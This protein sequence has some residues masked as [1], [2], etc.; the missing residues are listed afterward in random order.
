M[1]NLNNG[2]QVEQR[3]RQLQGIGP[4]TI[5][6]TSLTEITKEIRQGHS[7][8][9]ICLQ[10]NKEYSFNVEPA[11]MQKLLEEYAE[12]FQE[13]KRLPPTREIDHH[14]TL[15]EGAEPIN[16]RPYRYAYF[17][18]AEIENKY[19]RC[20][21]LGLFGQAPVLFLHRYYLLKK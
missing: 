1:E 16:V 21:I 11:N 12:L 2:F 17:Q 15:K 14:I 10:I 7:V 13:P 8:F 20:W 18:K 4:Q 19:M 6:A 5:Q 9:A 3:K